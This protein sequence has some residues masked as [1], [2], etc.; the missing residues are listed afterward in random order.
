MSA[1]AQN[2]ILYLNPLATN[3]KFSIY[4]H[5]ALDSTNTLSFQLDGNAAR[6]NVFEKVINNDILNDKE[7][8]YI[9]SMSVINVKYHLLI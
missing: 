5:N 3:S 9:E 2:T 8:I 1:Q 7:N 4:Y 6:T